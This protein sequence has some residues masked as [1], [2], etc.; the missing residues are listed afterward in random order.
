[1]IEAVIVYVEKKIDLQ[2]CGSK[3]IRTGT[4][5]EKKFWKNGKWSQETH[6]NLRISP[7]RRD[8]E[9]REIP[10]T[11]KEVQHRKKGIRLVIEELK[12]GLYTKTAKLKRYMER[13][14]WSEPV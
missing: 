2:A 5:L 4:L 11:W 14:N 3:K 12:Q 13:V 8:K 7:D 10:G 1:M 6:K 9:E